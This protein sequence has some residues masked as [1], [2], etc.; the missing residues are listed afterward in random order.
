M[1]VDGQKHS[2]SFPDEE[3]VKWDFLSVVM[4]D[5]YGLKK[6]GRSL[7]NILDVGSNVG[8][9]AAAARAHFPNALIHAY[10]PNPSIRTHIE[11]QA[12]EFGFKYFGE[13]VGGHAGSVEM[14]FQAGSDIN[15]G[16]VDEGKGG[17]ITKIPLETAVERMGGAIDLIKMDCEGS[18]WEMF[19]ESGCWPQIAAV[20]MEY[21]LFK[22]ERHADV[23]R[24]V[25]SLGYAIDHW[26]F[27]PDCH[28]GHLRASRT[29]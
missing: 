26:T 10:E 13:A 16:R 27:A 24:T 28:Y 29:S 17:T 9:F 21:H 20:T 14:S 4:E 3:G 15:L 19:R 6:S 8:F 11:N 2:L 5:V 1:S 25:E 23:K 7:R 12:K 18:E 22:G